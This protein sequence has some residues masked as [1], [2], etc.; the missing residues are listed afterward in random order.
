MTYNNQGL[1]AIQEILCPNNITQDTK[2]THEIDTNLKNESTNEDQVT[3]NNIHKTIKTT[4][5]SSSS[6]ITNTEFIPQIFYSLHNIMKNPNISNQLE[7]AT[8]VIRH[9]LRSSKQVLMEHNDTRILLN[10]SIP[11][12]EKFIQLKEHEVA[13]KRNV[14]RNLGQKIKDMNE[15]TES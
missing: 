13:M 12:W 8:G 9:K 1:Q 11:N 14:L 15:T 10:K 6:S 5:T 2:I 4:N 7:T 3:E